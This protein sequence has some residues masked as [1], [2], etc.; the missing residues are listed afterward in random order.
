M[1]LVDAVF[2]AQKPQAS[3]QR[4]V[5]KFLSFEL[6]E[7]EQAPFCTSV[8]HVASSALFLQSGLSRPVVELATRTQTHRKRHVI[9][10]INLSRSPV[11]AHQVLGFHSI[12]ELQY[13]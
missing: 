12:I 4:S 6:A 7:S 3:A 2:G 10:L 8:L 1:L 13:F 11:Y 5:T 9:V